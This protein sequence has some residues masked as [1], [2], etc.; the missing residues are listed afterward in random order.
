MPP[1]SFAPSS[2]VNRPLF[3]CL[4]LLAL[5]LLATHAAQAGTLSRDE[6]QRRFGV[7]YQ[8]EEKL[9]D[10]PAWP[11]TSSLEKEVG[12]VAYAFESIDIAPLPGF[13][14]SPMNFLITIDRKGNFMGVE[15]LQQREPVFTFRDL[16]GLGDTPLREFIA[17]YAGK[18]INQPFVIALDA[19]RNH[20]GMSANRG[21]HAT[22]D[23]I[24]KATTS[25]RIIHQT[26][27]T[28]AL[29][30][31][32]ARLGFADR[33][34]RGPPGKPVAEVLERPSF[35][36]MLERGMIGRLR[37]SNRDVEK[38][39]AGTDGANVDED[40]LAHPDELYVDL[41]VAYLNAPTIGRAILGDEQYKVVMERN[42][43][44]RHLWWIA[45]A[46]RFRIVDDDF[47]PGTQSPRVAMAQDG[48]FLDFRDQGFDPV[49]IA[50][51]PELNSSRLFGVA[52]DANIDPAQALDIVL[53]VTRAKGMVLPTL[54]HQQ[55]R[56]AYQ[57]PSQ[58]FVYPPAPLPEW[59]LAWKSRWAD[60]VVI[61]L[62]LLILGVVLAR[63][64]WISVNPRRLSNFR[65]AFLAY[66]LGYLGWYAQGQLSI[67]QIT[68]AVKTLKSGLG[69][70][71]YL[72]DPVS[73]LLI[74]FTL[75]SFIVWGRGT[76][77]GW[78]CPF[79][80]LQ[81]FVGLVAR[82]LRFAQLNIPSKLARQLE[83][84]RYVVLAV[85][86]LAAFFAPELG[87][88][89]NE[90]EPFKTSI[91]VAFNRGWPYV[92]YAL[93]LLA[94]GAFYYK[95]FC[96]FLCPLG[97]VMSLGGKL[98]RL[99]WLTRR[100]ECGKP[101]QRCKVVCNYAAIEPSGEIRYDACFQC[102]DC[103]GVYHDAQRCVPV[104][105]YE[106]KGKVLVPKV[107]GA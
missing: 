9:T 63:P 57:P 69:F 102:L 40:A 34:K 99:D 18:S 29:D 87:V 95:F 7:P 80:A 33:S 91:T 8:V 53:T 83:W 78:L 28:S 81:E 89:L 17:Q 82:K 35:A 19:A 4:L 105:L 52:A 39:F 14:G 12:P 59:L 96:R 58:L 3:R 68:G 103:V 47:T 27:L 2:W 79:G 48:G 13:E 77:C 42:F 46:G 54:T 41:Y 44:N 31:A 92:V 71:A 32:R 85:L 101:C 20:T 60:L 25:V 97:A 93:L 6:I 22:L 76:F 49:G 73:L 75:I 61:G 98:R 94:A 11:V 15:V 50:G 1:C 88:S 65:L 21:T 67:V 51:A 43:D 62:S 10:I 56:L 66:T 104:M 5:E 74:G 24:S 72:Y 64:R 90:V 30:V 107:Q 36:Q 106:K 70:S 16:G 26:V 84:G 38:L 45:S 37:L 23:G 100:I 55:V 86:L